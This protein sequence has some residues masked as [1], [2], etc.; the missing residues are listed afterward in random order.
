MNN[1]KLTVAVAIYNIE[2]YLPKCLESLLNQTEKNGYEI[3]LINDGSTD[4]SRKICEE[5]IGKGLNA[6]IIDKENGGLTSVRNLS[7]DLAK[8]ENILFLDGDDYIENETM[9]II[10]KELE[11]YDL[12]VFG[13]NWINE[14]NIYTDERFLK[15]KIYDENKKIRNLIFSNEINSSVWNKIFKVDILKENNIRFLEFKSCEDIPFTNEYLQKCK[16]VKI[17]NRVLYQY[18]YREN[19]LSNQKKYDFYL[20][21]LKLILYFLKKINIKTDDFYNYTV[22]EYVYLIREMRKNN[23]FKNDKILFELRE[24]IEKN[25]DLIRVI[26]NKKLK[27]KMKLRYLKLKGRN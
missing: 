10:F 27:F 11:D 13:F 5:F 20:N 14:N 12:L 7:I 17:I 15:N 2:K 4:N 23:I 16:N 18:L 24:K 25:I 3:L 1:I 26:F 9:K 22:K 21:H 8:G 19:S 6:E